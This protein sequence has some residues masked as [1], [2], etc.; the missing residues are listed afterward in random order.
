[1]QKIG[2]RIAQRPDHRTSSEVLEA[3]RKLGVAQVTDC[4]GRLYGSVGLTPLNGPGLRVAGIALTVKT[5]PGDNLLIHQ[6]IDMA[7]PGDIIVVDGG[8]C[9]ANALVGELMMMQS[10]KR[11]VTGFVIDGAVRDAEAFDAA[12]F[13]CFARG[14][15]HRGPFKD[16][17]GEINVPVSVGGL[18]VQP[19]DVVLG[20]CDGVVAIPASHAEDLLQLAQA[21]AQAEARG[22]ERIKAGTYEKPWQAAALARLEKDYK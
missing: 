12:G 6:A 21:K 7:Q 3:Y 5:R 10:M 16:G 8:G 4:M 18:V 14:V 9:V 15:S 20:D 22:M 11:G 2:F 1:M 19:G 13:A 17:P